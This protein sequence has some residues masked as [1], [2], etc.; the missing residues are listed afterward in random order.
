MAK[1]PSSTDYIT[2]GIG[3]LVAIGGAFGY[4]KSGKSRIALQSD[5]NADIIVQEVQIIG[6]FWKV[7]V[8]W[9]YQLLCWLLSHPNTTTSV[10]SCTSKITSNFFRSRDHHQALTLTENLAI[11]KFKRNSAGCF[12]Y[13]TPFYGGLNVHVVLCSPS[14]N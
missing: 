5:S 10:L 11:K 12:I 1:T 8:P 9:I 2:Y 6:N 14:P 3:A 7:N 13:V 4:M